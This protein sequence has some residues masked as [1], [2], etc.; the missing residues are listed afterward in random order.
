MP[1]PHIVKRLTIDSVP[2]TVIQV[3]GFYIFLELTP[4]NLTSLES[5]PRARFY[6]HLCCSSTPLDI[7][8][9]SIDYR[10]AG[11][12]PDYFK[13]Q[14][15]DWIYPE[16]YEQNVQR[17]LEALQQRTW[18]WLPRVKQILNDFYTNE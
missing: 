17:C 16:F 8:H 18:G 9:L 4:P 1:E 6:M 11:T 3:G 5:K 7:D 12:R 2:R 10:E 15:I 14:T 13:K